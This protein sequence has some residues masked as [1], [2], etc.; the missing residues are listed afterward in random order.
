MDVFWPVFS[1]FF[2]FVNLTQNDAFCMFECVLSFRILPGDLVVCVVEE[3]CSV[4]LC[5]VSELLS[6]IPTPLVESPKTRQKGGE[7]N[8]A[9][10]MIRAK[11][12]VGSRDQHP[13]VDA[14]Q[15]ECQKT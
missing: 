10:S 15:T 13:Q 9:T 1:C 12:R 14:P 6:E 5:F 2:A 8:A 3:T 11:S 7:S 4:N